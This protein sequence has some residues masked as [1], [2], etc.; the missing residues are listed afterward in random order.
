[1]QLFELFALASVM[2]TATATAIPKAHVEDIAKRD[3][4]D[5]RALFRGGAKAGIQDPGLAECWWLVKAL[6][7]VTFSQK[8]GVLHKVIILQYYTH[9]VANLDCSRT[10]PLVQLDFEL[11][12]TFRRSFKDDIIQRNNLG[13]TSMSSQGAFGDTGLGVSDSSRTGNLTWKWPWRC[14]AETRTYVPVF[15]VL[16]RNFCLDH[17]MLNGAL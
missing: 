15:K 14:P 8:T 16:H 6:D 13:I 9:T 10:T 4:I 7:G 12:A 2:C 1:M 11:H 17:N 5:D 3:G